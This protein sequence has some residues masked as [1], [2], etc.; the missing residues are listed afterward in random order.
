MRYWLVL[1]Y[2]QLRAHSNF[3][4]IRVRSQDP[5]MCLPLK[6]VDGQTRTNCTK[7]LITE[8]VQLY[9]LGFR[10]PA[11]VYTINVN[12][13]HPDLALLDLLSQVWL[14]VCKLASCT[15]QEMTFPS[16]TKV[17]SAHPT[18]SCVSE[19]NCIAPHHA[20]VKR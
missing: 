7:Q 8:K 10:I 18:R 11:V 4:G 3:F 5:K 17:T 20:R 6:V 19:Q 1:T 12:A 15:H 14:H 9:P 16:V 13:T 2:C